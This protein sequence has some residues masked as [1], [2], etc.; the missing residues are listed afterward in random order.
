MSDAKSS[1]EPTMEEILAT[2][3]R[4]IADDERQGAAGPV[5]QA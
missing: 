4:I 1:T 5:G 3:R 2:I